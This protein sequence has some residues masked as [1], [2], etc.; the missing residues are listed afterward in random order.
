MQDYVIGVDVGGTN[1]KAGAVDYKGKILARQRA[2]TEADQGAE[3]ILNKLQSMVTQLRGAT[4]DGHLCGIGFGVPGAIRS[5]EGIVTQAPNVPSWDGLPVRKMLEERL[6][7]PCFI[8]NDAN[9]IAIGEMWMGS[10]RGYDHI[11]CLTLGTGVGGGVVIDGELLRGADGMAAELGHI[12]VQADGPR[13]NC[14]SYGCLESY[15]SATGILRMLA[16]ERKQQRPSSIF[17]LPENRI[18][19]A[20]IYEHARK[21]D[22]L[23]NEV[24][25]KA[26]KGLGVGLATLVNMFNPE[27]LIMGGGI[28]AAWDLLVP[29]ALETMHQRAFHAMAERVKVMPALMEDDAGIFGTAYIAWNQLQMAGGKVSHE[30]SLAPWGFWQVLEEGSDYKVKRIFI[31]AGHRLSYQKHKHREETWMIA[32]GEPLVVIDG[33]EHRLRAGDTIRI[34]KAAAH[35][36]GNPGTTPVVF[37]EVQRGTYFGEDDIERLQDDYQRS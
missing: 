27:I 8:E 15:A 36:I 1:I 29:P 28:A 14:G 35:R 22:P 24:L 18:T 31:H 23:C 16:E 34:G 7:L 21:G 5:R 11:C 12:A 25:R 26:G 30:R 6:Q 10:G 33:V 32:A 2:L 19:T 9:A 4:S 17:Q 13:C 37:F 3:P 20:M